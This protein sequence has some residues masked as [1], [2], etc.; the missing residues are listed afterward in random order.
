V[1]HNEQ[2]VSKAVEG[3]KAFA[4]SRDLGKPLKVLSRDDRFVTGVGCEWDGEIR[5]AF[6]FGSEQRVANAIEARRRV[7]EWMA[8][9]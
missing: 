9:G 7:A 6:A 3:L 1:T 5:T 2:E 4:A 8:E